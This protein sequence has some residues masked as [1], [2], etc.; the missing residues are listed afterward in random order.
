MRDAD[1]VCRLGRVYPTAPGQRTWVS[2]PR[3]L[4]MLAGRPEDPRASIILI[5]APAGAGKSVL[6]RQW[7]E[8]DD[9][10]H[11]EIP[12][13]PGLDEPLALIH[14]LV[15]LLESVGPA[16]RNLR[17]SITSTEPRLSTIVL[18]AL[19]RLAASRSQ[20]YVLV[21]DDVHLLRNPACDG[22]LR[23]VCNGTPDESQ[24]ILLG[25]GEA[26][27]WLARA[28]AEGRL[29]EIT[30]L[31]LRFEASEA[32]DLFQ[33]MGVVSRGVDVD[34]VVATTEGWAVALYLTG[35]AMRRSTNGFSTALAEGIRNSNRFIGDYISTEVLHP[36]EPELQSFVIRTSVLDELRPELCDAVL[37]RNDSLALLSQL[38]EQ[39]QLMIPL[40]PGGRRLRYHHL[41]GEALLLE[42]SRRAPAEIPVLH[43]RASRW[44]ADN[45]LL[46]EAVRHAKAAGDLTEVGRLVWSASGNLIGSGDKDRLAIWLADLSEGQVAHDRWLCL[47]AA[48]VALQSGHTDRMD[49]WILR[50]ESHAG[51]NWRARAHDDSYA[52][53][54]ALIQALVGR[55]GLS[56]TQV[57]ATAAL[58]GLPADSPYRAA[59]LFILGVALT[60]NRDVESGRRALADAERLAR[61]LD[62]PIV[63]ADSLSWQGVLAL[64]A[65]D[66]PNA[67]RIIRRA[68]GIV[69]EH[70]LERLTTA[71]HSLTAQALLQAL[72]HEPAASTTLAT[73]RRLTAQ[74]GDT[75]PWFGVCGRLIQARAA[76]SL[77]EGAL[78][79]QLLTEAK[80]RMTPDLHD[81]LAQDLQNETDRA[82]SLINVDGVTSPA[83]TPAELRILQFLPSHVQLP[84]IGEHLFVSTNTVKSHVMA[85]HRK[86][87]VTSR[88]EAV[89]RARE[90]GLLEAPPVD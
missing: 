55:A 72:A 25:R 34:D 80:A 73:A 6:A 16:A 33:G 18:P 59:A 1:V 63:Q 39:L 62:V 12:A 7:L 41:L 83:L 5:S 49:R 44:Y 15:D 71:A 51:E 54:L 56:T 26:P 46:D 24:V 85:I 47:A 67:R 32:A 22:V 45:G 43:A 31:D 11:L 35:L 21:V 89:V 52:A 10:A 78:A 90:L 75:V 68:T 8:T 64:S 13:T 42:L 3:L 53:Q 20:D 88:A 40:D 19:E 61:V 77:G 57:L 74:L 81:S 29:R 69:I 9:R 76:V 70:R 58:G 50:A 66:L 60:L 37:G 23:A 82:L 79:R 87:G 36:L 48:W 65:G 27:A 14:A 4:Q 30:G 28:R 17:A 2:R 38:Q 84:Q 86:L